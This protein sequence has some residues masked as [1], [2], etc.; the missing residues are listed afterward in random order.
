MAALITRIE[1][2]KR[3]RRQC[4]TK[5]V[6]IEGD[7]VFCYRLKGRT[8]AIVF[9]G[10]QRLTPSARMVNGDD[11]A[12]DEAVDCGRTINADLVLQAIEGGLIHGLAQATGATTGIA[13]GRATARR[14]G[15][16]GLPRLVDSPDIN[17]ELIRSD[18]EPGG[19]AELAVPPV[20]PAV[21]NALFAATGRRWRHLP[22]RA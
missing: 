19:V 5:L 15:D 21:A 13:A 10:V 1:E 3:L 7:Q 14:I 20:G 6:T 11:A 8:P 17:I 4:R 18:E 22:L 2:A 12:L 16:L 9:A